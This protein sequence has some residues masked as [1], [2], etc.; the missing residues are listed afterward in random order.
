MVIHEM[1]AQET[2]GCRMDLE[3]ENR[4][5][6]GATV[7]SNSF[8][9]QYMAG[10]SGEY[11]KVYL[12]LLRHQQETIRV[13]AVAEALNHTE[14]DV[15][16]ALAYWQRVGVLAG[17][18]GSQAR[19]AKEAA[20]AGN[21]PGTAAGW[22]AAGNGPGIAADWEAAGN[23]LRT[24]ADRES[25]ETGS[26][27]AAG[28]EAAKPV[29]GA[30]AGP[31][32]EK[33]ISGAAAPGTAKPVSKAR[34]AAAAPGS[35]GTC[36]LSRLEGDAAF[37]QLIYIAEKY[38]NRPLTQ[39]DCQILAN[40]YGGLGFSAELLEYLIEY[41]VQ[42]RH[43][44][45]RYAEKVALGWHERQICTVEEARLVS[46][47]FS[48]EIFAVMKAMGLS[49]RNPADAEYAL[50]EKWFRTF[51]FSR[52]LVTEACDRT[53][54]AIHTPSFQY[55]DRILTDWKEAGVRTM[56]DVKALDEARRER[57]EAGKERAADARPGRRG[58]FRGA[59]RFHN[60]EEH[61]YDYNEIVWDVIHAGEKTG[62]NDGA[63]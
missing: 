25:A 40:L 12:Y 34:A 8:I 30:A 2:E 53:I 20:A 26:R 54:R 18:G 10:A 16:R 4:L 49:S 23:G 7:V 55:A 56:R 50:I 51:G 32:S 41:C 5:N 14:A 33:P 43:T 9:D 48:R 6:A 62:G 57:E 3:F 27:A 37:G 15:R 35:S 63:E 59:N 28:R 22:E 17:S 38:L 21:G 61:G 1:E 60:L 24:A 39:T 13:E 11:V 52:E 58:A 29:S 36:E 19:Q 45:L 47:G 31:E 46:R 44:S 42:N